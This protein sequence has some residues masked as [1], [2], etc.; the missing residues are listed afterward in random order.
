MRQFP[1]ASN[2]TLALKDYEDAL[3]DETQGMNVQEMGLFM[4][5]QAIQVSRQLSMEGQNTRASNSQGPRSLDY[6]KMIFSEG[7]QKNR[8]IKQKPTSKQSELLAFLGIEALYGGAAGGGKSSALLM[9]ALMFADVPGYNAILFRR[10]YQ[11]LSLPESLMDRS[12]QWL[13]G[14]EAHWNASTHTWTFPSS[15][16][17]SFGYLENDQDKFRYQSAEFQYIGFDELTQ[18]NEDQYKFLFSRL[19]R[20]RTASVPLRMRTASNPGNIGHDWVKRRF[21]EEGLLK[22]RLFIPAKLADNPHLDQTSYI[23]SLNQ[24]DPITRKQYLEGDWTA[25]H[26]AGK[27]K[28]EWF[29][30]VDNA[31]VDAARVRY[32]DMAA[33]TAKPGKDPDY[34]VGVRLAMKDGFY[35]IEDIQRFRETPAV[36]EQRIRQTAMLDRDEL[37][38]TH[39][40]ITVYMEVE[41]GSEGISLADHY[42]RNVLLEFDFRTERTTGN[43]E[44]RA[45]PVSSAAEQG[46]INLVRGAWINDFFDE[47]EGFPLGAHDD[48]VDAL[49]GAFA[50]V[51][52]A[53][54]IQAFSAPIDW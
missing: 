42:S 3:A 53:A 41:P 22:G 26:G 21:M 29:Q 1:E 37:A 38:T 33:T 12:L 54:P 45:N 5:L 14:T 34:T 24:L 32:W 49:S 30:L 16:R 15:A 51:Q 11:D 7:L 36:V 10:T 6:L 52:N 43:K 31:P 23:K 4:H 44:L 27:F 2:M 50:T 46:R 8:W 40:G 13:G 39:Q 9:G 20:L 28:R 48:Q 18:F 47:A 25:K 17:L 19:R 35:W